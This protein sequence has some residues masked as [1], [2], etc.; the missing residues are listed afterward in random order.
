MDNAFFKS[1][2]RFNQR[3]KSLINTK[4]IE[5]GD[6]I[7]LMS[8]FSFRSNI[9]YIFAASYLSIMNLSRVS[10]LISN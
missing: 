5:F 8:K 3:Y 10:F 2:K 6:K 7:I 4:Q 9:R 1:R